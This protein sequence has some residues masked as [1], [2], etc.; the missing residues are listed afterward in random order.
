MPHRDTLRRPPCHPTRLPLVAACLLALVAPLALTL[1]APGARA[2]SAPE[3]NLSTQ[4]GP[5]NPLQVD[6]LDRDAPPP[7]PT[8]CVAESGDRYDDDCF[9]VS[10]AISATEPVTDVTVTVVEHRGLYVDPLVTTIDALETDRTQI[11]SYAVRA[12]TTGLHTLTF[13]VSAPGAEPRRVGLPYVWR[14]SGAPIPGEDSLAGRMYAA[15]GFDSYDCTATAECDFRTAQRVVFVDDE[16]A[17]RALASNGKVG[18]GTGQSCSPYHHDEASGLVQVGDA[19]IGRVTRQAAFF[20]GE[21]YTRLVDPRPGRR[22]D[23]LWQYGASVDEG[24]GVVE[25][26]LRLRDSGRFRLRY[27]VDTTRYGRPGVGATYS[28]S[29]RGTYRIGR[30]GRLTLLDARRE[31]SRVATL[32][33]VAT[34]TG[35]PRAARRGV[36][37]DLAINPPTGRSFVD[38]NKLIPLPIG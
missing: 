27:A 11:V 25:Q 32:A 5:G 24:R 6:R 9:D 22:L 31:V 21:R 36:W 15:N 4:P 29:L 23:G 20:D 19:T 28:R 13:E 3:L 38:G 7:S 18:C 14:A 26:R 10:L 1:A 34:P 33:V 37:L 16:R 35:R 2:T 8:V 17:G 30:H 12:R